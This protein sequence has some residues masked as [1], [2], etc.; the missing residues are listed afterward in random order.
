MVSRL[1]DWP[2]RLSEFLKERSKTPFEWGKNDCMSFTCAAFEAVTGVNHFAPYSDYSCE[3]SA[4]RMLDQH[5]GVIGIIDSCLG[6]GRRDIL[7]AGRGDIVIVKMPDIMGGVVDD[8]GQK[9]AL[10]TKDG[11]IRVPLTKAWRYWSY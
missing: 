2:K 5:R 11:L 3:E 1:P 4:K 9:I 6:L 8:S 7:S 10:V